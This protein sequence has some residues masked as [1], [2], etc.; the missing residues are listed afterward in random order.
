MSWKIQNNVEINNRNVYH[1]ETNKGWAVVILPDNI[2]IDNYHRG[3][4]HIH[5][6]H[7]KHY[8]YEE[9]E[10]YSM[11]EVFEIVCLHIDKNNDLILK[12]LI[13][14]LKGLGGIK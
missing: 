12:K 6:N 10:Q 1:A 7:S 14:E 13:K 11:L 5:P 4:V 8:I 3:C 9:L 2:I